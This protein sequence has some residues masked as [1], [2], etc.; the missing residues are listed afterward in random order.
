MP[1]PQLSDGNR[2]IITSL[3]EGGFSNKDIATSVN[4]T[5]DYAQKLR[6]RWIITESIFIKQDCTD[7]TKLLLFHLAELLDLLAEKS[8]IYLDEMQL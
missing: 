6:K 3:L 8:N 5:P 2:S 1:G 7:Q 4:I